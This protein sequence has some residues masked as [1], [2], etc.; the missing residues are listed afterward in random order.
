[1]GEVRVP[2]TLTNVPWLKVFGRGKAAIHV[3]KAHMVPVSRDN[4]DHS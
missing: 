3:T 2:P 1:M 4:S